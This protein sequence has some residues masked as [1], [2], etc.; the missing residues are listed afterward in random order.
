M[1]DA[2]VIREI[3]Q[4]QKDRG[5]E[6]AGTF[7]IADSLEKLQSFWDAMERTT[8]RQA[9]VC[10]E[11]CR[12]INPKSVPKMLEALRGIV[13]GGDATQVTS[14]M[15]DCIDAIALAETSDGD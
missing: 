4:D 7:A 2:D 12:G 15:Q 9:F 14:A 3:A 5:F 8:V 6:S 1:S 13:A 11:H 10:V